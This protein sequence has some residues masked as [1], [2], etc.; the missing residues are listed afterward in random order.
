MRIYVSR[1]VISET[2]P[3]HVSEVEDFLIENIR[4]LGHDPLVVDEYVR[5]SLQAEE[6]LE[7]ASSDAYS[8]MQDELEK[9]ENES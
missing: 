7:E 9:Q 1:D 5:Q 3:G 6:I 4:S 8:R 2:F